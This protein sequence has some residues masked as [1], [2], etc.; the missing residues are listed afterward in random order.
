MLDMSAFS[1]R[2]STSSVAPSDVTSSPYRRVLPTLGRRFLAWSLELA[3]LAGSIAGPL[4]LGGQ[5]NQRPETTT[6]ALT[7]VLKIAQRTLA[8][9]LGL[10]PRSLPQKVTP[11]TN[12]LWSLA[13]GLPLVLAVAHLY[14]MGRYGRSWPKQWLGVQVLALNGQLPGWQRA[15]LREGLGKWGGPGL[16]AYGIWQISGGFP[17][18]LILSGLGLLALVGEGLTGLNNRPRRSWH[19]WL[20]GTCVVDQETGAIIRLST[21]WGEEV[22]P[23]TAAPSDSQAVVWGEMYGGLTSVVLDPVNAAWPQQP[24]QRFSLGLAIVCLATVG[25][26]AGIGSYHFFQFAQ[27]T[28]NSTVTLYDE[29]VATIANPELDAAARRAAVLALGNLSDKRV[30]PLLVDLVAQTEDS[31]WLD[32]LQQALIAQGVEAMPALRRLNQS[33]A[34]DLPLQNNVNRH[35][36]AAMRLQTVNQILVKLIL[37]RTGDRSDNPNLSHLHLGRLA[38]RGHEFKLVLQNQDLSGIQWRGTV[39]NGAQLQGSNFFHPGDDGHP[40][41]YDD[42]TTDLSGADLTQANLVGANLSFSYLVGSSLMNARLNHVNLT[43]ADLTRVN[44]ENAQLIQADLTQASLP[45]ARLS[46]ADLTAARLPGANLEAARLLGVTA[47]GAQMPDA[48][49]V[50]IAAKS[51]NFTD[52]DFSGAILEDADLTGAYLQGANLSQA[53]LRNASLRDTDL[54]QVSFQNAD[55]T[56]ADLAGAI[57]VAPSGSSDHDFVAAMPDFWLRHRLAGVDFS[58]VQNLAPEQLTYICTQGAIHPACDSLKPQ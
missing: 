56:G 29:L 7:P 28:N 52:A 36:T 18:L 41:T 23:P 6:T 39:L 35:H 30:A 38:H 45:Q 50:G 26:L 12:I 4:Y 48:V 55:L 25:G 31:Q 19:D 42:K 20:A 44:L 14:S 11:L 49:M 5:L 16:V 46:K 54:R 2:Q 17:G 15:L 3:I 21:L 8:K 13:V 22:M 27:S 40:D 10:S 57:L 1:R 53:N 47:A 37:L 9:S 33:L 58:D 24:I 34:A 32:V 43:L 51:A